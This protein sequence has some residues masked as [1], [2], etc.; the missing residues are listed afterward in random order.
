MAVTAPDTETR[1]VVE[2]LRGSEFVKA[3]AVAQAAAQTLA[4]RGLIA[5]IRT[6]ERDYE[7]R[8]PQLEAELAAAIAGVKQA[9]AALL[10]AQ[11]RANAALGAKSTASYTYSAQRDR[12][13]QQ[14]RE[15]AHPALASW[16]REMLDELDRTRKKFSYIETR[17]THPITRLARRI[18]TNNAQ[19][20]AKRVAA[21]MAA[22]EEAERLKLELDDQTSI[23]EML[24]ALA[25]GLP[26]VE[27]PKIEK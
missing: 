6:L 5:Q 7:K 14:L 3:A 8:R 1:N 2:L 21:I 22:I 25:A 15:S 4:R 24:G 10:A 16:V 20:V 27:D 9:E 23:P 11:K 19:S 12:L 13:E 17:E 26:L 18:V